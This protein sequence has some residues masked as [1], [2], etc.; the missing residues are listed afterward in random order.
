MTAG[1]TSEDYLGNNLH[2]HPAAYWC[3]DCHRFTLD[4]NHLVDP[5]NEGWLR[6]LFLLTHK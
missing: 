3:A 6:P 5:L 2:N 1:P 4:C